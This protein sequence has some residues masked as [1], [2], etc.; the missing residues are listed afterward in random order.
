MA[1][2]TKNQKAKIA[3]RLAVAAVVVVILTYV[4]KEIVKENLNELHNSLASAD[5]QYRTE[6]G[7]STISLQVFTTQQQIEGLKLE[8]E[9]NDTHRDFSALIA[10]GIL[11]AQQAQSE[12]DVTFDSVSRL[13][14][15]LPAG[16]RDLRR[17][18]DESQEQIGK[19]KQQV[20]D[21][22]KPKPEHDVRRFIEVQVAMLM[23]LV[24]GIPVTVLGD[25]AET[26]AQRVQEAAE[27]V[28]RL[29]TRAIYAL[30]FL[31]ASLA[32]FAAFT[33][34]KTEAA[35]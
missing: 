13:I 26:A 35:E 4:L 9:R 16:A 30:F 33:G 20:N 6:L 22:L 2:R 7:Q 3:K 18:R 21:I 10:Q 25:K 19:T 27:R 24:N 17:L 14:D 1:H 28:I 11:Q 5:A 15:K 34:S 8:A 29:C 31:G 23:T 32:L 12:V